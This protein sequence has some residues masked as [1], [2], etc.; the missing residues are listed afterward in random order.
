MLQY[1]TIRHLIFKKIRVKPR[2]ETFTVQPPPLKNS[3]AFDFFYQC[4][5]EHKNRFTLIRMNIDGFPER[6][7]ASSTKPTK[8]NINWMWRKNSWNL[9][10]E[11]RYKIVMQ[12]HFHICDILTVIRNPSRCSRALDRAGLTVEDWKV[13]NR[14]ENPCFWLFI[15]KLKNTTQTLFTFSAQFSISTPNQSRSESCCSSTNKP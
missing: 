14:N 2:A 1:Q 15:K 5:S 4:R 7:S 9:I 13:S 12:M 10:E 8:H 11:A 6:S 3:I